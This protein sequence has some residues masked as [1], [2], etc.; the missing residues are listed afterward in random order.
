MSTQ[1]I[2]ALLL[3]GSLSVKIPIIRNIVAS[4]STNG[5]SPLS[6]SLEILSQSLYLTYFLRSGES[7]SLYAETVSVYL[8]NIALFFTLNYFPLT[9]SSPDAKPIF[10]DLSSTISNVISWL[11]LVSIL[12]LAPTFL[13]PVFLLVSSPINWS[14]V[15]PLISN[16]YTNGTTGALS[17]FSQVNVCIGAVLRSFT[18]I[19]DIGTVSAVI[20]SVIGTSLQLVLLAQVL[21]YNFLN[22][23]ELVQSA[24]GVGQ[25]FVSE[26]YGKVV[27]KKNEL[28][29]MDPERVKLLKEK[30]GEFRLRTS[31]LGDNMGEFN[32]EDEVSKRLPTRLK[33]KSFRVV[34]DEALNYKVAVE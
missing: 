22:G 5:L 27:E 30:F 8:Q 33:G 20:P 18:I 24:V 9:S 1:A 29:S 13:L 15:L 4:K 17:V 19:K 6:L 31:T 10:T 26:V 32:L 3:F 12:A 14:S 11:I 2:G 34:A 28:E 23:N 16:N 21:Y 25:K 7:I